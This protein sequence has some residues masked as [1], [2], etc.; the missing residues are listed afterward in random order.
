MK[1]PS[2]I[3]STFV[4]ERSFTAKPEKVFAAFADP[5]KK[6]RWFLEG[7]NSEG[8]VYEMDFKVG[9][10]E[11]T[12]FVFSGG[13]P[14]PDGTPMGN[15]TSYHDIVPNERIVMAYTML[16][17]NQRISTSLA[18]FVFLASET[19]TELIFTEQGAYF[20]GADGPQIR[21]MGWQELL[22]QLAKEIK[23]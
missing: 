5:D 19:G 22:K 11:R 13:G 20:E 8:T 10:F 2:V 6:R 16:I 9:G 14:L 23:N 7:K 4:I 18:T 21:E 3:H 12:R 15:D 17:N 1:E